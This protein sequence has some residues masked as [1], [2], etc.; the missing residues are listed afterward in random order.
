MVNQY[1]ESNKI[2]YYVLTVTALCYTA[3][4]VYIGVF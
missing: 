2:F 3:V 4:G 1:F